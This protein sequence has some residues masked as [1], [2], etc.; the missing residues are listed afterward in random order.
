M[1]DFSNTSVEQPDFR[2]ESTIDQ[3]AV[4]IPRFGYSSTWCE[5][6]SSLSSLKWFPS[7]W[8]QNTQ[9]LHES[10]TIFTIRAPSKHCNDLHIFRLNTH[11]TISWSVLPSV[12]PFQHSWS[13]EKRFTR[14]SS[15]KCN[16]AYFISPASKVTWLLTISWDHAYVVPNVPCNA[17]RVYWNYPWFRLRT[18]CVSK[19]NN[20]PTLNPKP[21]YSRC[22]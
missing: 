8:W 9:H 16:I 2:A 13:I 22:N 19:Q 7:S 21:S 6:F 3:L 20:N 12:S 18:L 17:A 5:N 14:R 1:A 11:W 15:G 4:Y 10:C